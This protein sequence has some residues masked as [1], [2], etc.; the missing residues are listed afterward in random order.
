MKKLKLLI[1]FVIFFSIK[2]LSF[3]QTIKFQDDS[4]TESIVLK[5]G[6]VINYKS[7]L[8]KFENNFYFKYSDGINYKIN[9]DSISNTIENFEQLKSNKLTYYLTKFAN[10]SQTGIGLQITGAVLSYALT[11]VNANP[12]IFI[13]PSAISVTGFIVW[14]AFPL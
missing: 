6:S 2:N 8:F 13:A 5:N 4:E 7:K 3:S 11:F 14:T 9:I 10:N 1:L 12:L